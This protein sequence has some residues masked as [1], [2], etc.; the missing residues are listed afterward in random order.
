MT[1]RRTRRTTLLAAGLL[2]LPAALRSQSVPTDLAE[3]RA[4]FSQ[5]LMTNPASPRKA[6]ARQE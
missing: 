1:L 2:L 6:I 4:S 5:W 3:E